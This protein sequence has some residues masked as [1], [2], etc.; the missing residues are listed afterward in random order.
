ML[1]LPDVLS[2]APLPIA[3]LLLP[4]KLFRSASEPMA[5]LV[6]PVELTESAFR[7]VAVLKLPV[8]PWRVAHSFQHSR[9]EKVN[10]LSV[11]VLSQTVWHTHELRARPGCAIRAKTHS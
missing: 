3:V 2:S 1:L 5:V 8:V 6:E 7:P 4:V 11:T 10:D 9:V